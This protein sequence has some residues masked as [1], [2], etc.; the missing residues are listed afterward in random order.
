VED[1]N[2]PTQIGGKNGQNID[3]KQF[4]HGREWL[5]DGGGL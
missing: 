2:T 1:G 3:R 4:V 5:R